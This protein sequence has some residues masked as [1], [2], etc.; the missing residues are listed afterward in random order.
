MLVQKE[1]L[2]LSAFGPHSLREFQGRNSQGLRAQPGEG[3]QF[4][5]LP[6]FPKE[7]AKLPGVDEAKLKGV[8]L[9]R[10]NDVGMLFQWG[11]SLNHPQ[12]P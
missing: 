7:A 1:G 8:I 12:F 3:I 5:S 6:L 9:E 4:P 11:S 2:D 10:K